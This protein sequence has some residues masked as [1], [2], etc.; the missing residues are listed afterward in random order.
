[1]SQSDAGT[2]AVLLLPGFSMASL[3]ILTERFTLAAGRAPLLYSCS[4]EM[5]ASE[6]GIRVQARKL[7]PRPRE[8]HSLIVCGGRQPPTS[9][10]AC[11]EALD[12]M[13]VR[14]GCRIG[15]GSGVL[16][17][18]CAG[19]LDKRRCSLPEGLR[20]ALEQMGCGAIVMPGTFTRDGSIW[21]CWGED[22]VTT[23]LDT[24]L[25]ARSNNGYCGSSPLQGEVEDRSTLAEAQALMRNNLS[26]PL[27]TREVADYLGVSCKKLERI[28]RQFAG[29]LPARFYIGLRL[30]LAKQ[31]LHHSNCSIE[32]VGRRCGFA[33]ASHF[34]R[35]FRNHFGCSPRD[36]RQ[37][38]NASPEILAESRMLGVSA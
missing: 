32:E 21:T 15:V 22:A 11:V 4:D 6:H 31:L 19:L 9:L 17:L 16:V 30:S 5:V 18:A 26:E 36:E 10:H 29:Q 24:L 27:T 25:P 14:G 2:V 13:A 33:S 8:F 37:S 23:M 20:S 7:P 12:R 38:F 34:S 1:M 28:F 3:G 35:A